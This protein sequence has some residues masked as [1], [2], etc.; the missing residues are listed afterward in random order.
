MAPRRWRLRRA[1][2][3]EAVRGTN[4]PCMRKIARTA[5]GAKWRG[6]ESPRA[7]PD[8]ALRERPGPNPAL[9]VL[10]FQAAHRHPHAPACVGET[11]ARLVS[12]QTLNLDRENR[13]EIAHDRVPRFAAFGRHV[14]LPAGGSEIDATRLQRVNGHRVAQHVDV[15][16]LLRQTPGERFPFISARATAIYAQLSVGR[17]M[18]RIAFNRDDIDCLRLVR[19]NLNGEAKV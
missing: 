9:R 19:V 11:G 1:T 16:V 10:Q 14:N 6:P 13:R 18:F 12:W 8:S 15:A 4:P 3:S 17:K 7:T 5:F 2:G